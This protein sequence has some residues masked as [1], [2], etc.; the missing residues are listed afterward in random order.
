MCFKVQV[1]FELCHITCLRRL[2]ACAAPCNVERLP[3]NAMHVCLPMLC[4]AVLS[5]R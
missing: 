5:C 4:C 3:D 1:C 2:A